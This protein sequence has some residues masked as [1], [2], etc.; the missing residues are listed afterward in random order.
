MARALHILDRTQRALLEVGKQANIVGAAV[1]AQPG[2]MQAYFG[3]TKC[4]VADAVEIDVPAKST[5]TVDLS[6]PSASN[7][8]TKTVDLTSED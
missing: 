5:E 4:N 2:S 3:A 1:G 8:A 6:S 7:A